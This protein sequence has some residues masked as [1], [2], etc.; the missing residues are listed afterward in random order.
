MVIMCSNLLRPAGV[1]LAPAT[2]ELKVFRAEE[3]PRSE[4]II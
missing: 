1:Q 2:M 4:M 3:V